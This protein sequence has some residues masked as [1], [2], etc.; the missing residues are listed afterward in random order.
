MNEP[1][2]DDQEYHNKVMQLAVKLN[3]FLTD[4]KE[5]FDLQ[6]NALLT[7]LALAGASSDLSRA[8]FC[9]VVAWQLNNYM[10][11]DGDRPEYIN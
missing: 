4:Q 3:T 2:I 8:E 9:A 7:V 6:V 5:P 10:S 11:H 1:L